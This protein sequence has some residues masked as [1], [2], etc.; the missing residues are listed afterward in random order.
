MSRSRPIKKTRDQDHTSSRLMSRPPAQGQDRDETETTK[1]GLE[2]FIN[3]FYLGLFKRLHWNEFLK[4]K[5]SI[6][7]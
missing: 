7:Y 4:V 1:I 3:G 6:C 5:C 2:I